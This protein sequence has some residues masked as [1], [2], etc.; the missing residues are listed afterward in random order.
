MVR[1]FISPDWPGELPDDTPPH[2]PGT[3]RPAMLIRRR[4]FERIGPFDEAY[5]KTDFMD[6]YGRAITLG[7]RTR[8]LPDVLL[9][10]RIHASNT[11]RVQRQAQREENLLSL[12]R[13]LDLARGADRARP[14][15]S[16]AGVTPDDRSDRR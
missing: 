5:Q 4:A 12:K 14:T 16:A 15:E 7:F 8:M 11:G 9:L 1:Q 3:V 10:R 6:W 2:Q 13:K